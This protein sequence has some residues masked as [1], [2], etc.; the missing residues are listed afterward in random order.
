MKTN[1]PVTQVEQ[2]YP[3]GKYIVS[4]TDLKGTLTYANQTFIDISGF[5]REELIGKNHNVVRHPDMPAAAFAHLWATVKTGRPWRGMVKNRCK[6]GDHYWVEALIV[7][8]RQDDR[9]I[10]YM[11]VRTEPSRDQ[12]AAAETLYKQLNAQGGGLP[13]PSAWQRIPLRRK[14]IGLLLVIF[15]AQVATGLSHWLGLGG[16]AAHWLD[17]GLGALSLGATGWLF[18]ILR[19]M[20][21]IMGRITRRLDHIAQGDLTDSIPVHRVDELG[22]LNDALVAMQTHLKAMM[23]EIA[24]AA[25]V[26]KDNADGVSE[27]MHATSTA[28]QIQSDAVNRIASAIEELGASVREVA[29]DAQATAEAVL[30]SRV[31]LD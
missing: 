29:G 18:F 25:A 31:L 15:G 26:V 1:L 27:E 23:A 16:S 17:V 11:S 4:R 30:S 6:N 24:E 22:L 21:E 13:G 10:G 3:R 7:P 9:T 8:V 19:Q 14:L 20:L 12:V 5:S 2:P 28:S